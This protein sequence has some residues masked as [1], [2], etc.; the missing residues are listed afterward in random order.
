MK[1]DTL[2][3]FGIE[4]KDNISFL[5]VRSQNPMQSLRFPLDAPS[6]SY[7]KVKPTFFADGV[8]KSKI[9]PENIYF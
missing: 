8:L 3:S 1:I 2:S 5:T 9:P 6:I 4:W 7:G